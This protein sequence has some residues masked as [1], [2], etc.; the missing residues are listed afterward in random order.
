[1]NTL[2]PPTQ[3]RAGAAHIGA[4][5]LPCSPCGAAPGPSAPAG[6]ARGPSAFI[7]SVVCRGRRRLGAVLPTTASPLPA[8]RAHGNHSSAR[9]PCR[10]QQGPAGQAGSLISS[11]SASAP[12]GRGSWPSQLWAWDV[13]SKPA[14]TRPPASP[15]P[16]P[17]RALLNR[18]PVSPVTPPCTATTSDAGG[19]E[20]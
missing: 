9:Q 5:G 2:E 18:L 20:N 13:S 10:G 6:R 3:I 17:R 12:F 16:R 15:S 8:T 4:A 11:R 7:C 1:M 19:Q 14:P